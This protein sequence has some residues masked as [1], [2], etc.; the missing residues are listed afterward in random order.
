MAQVGRF[1]TRS[2]KF[3]KLIG[4]L[5]DGSRIWGGPYTPSQLLSGGAFI[6]VAL[7]TSN[8]WSFGSFLIDLPLAAA[9]TFGLVKLIGMIPTQRRT[10]IRMVVG[11]GTSITRPAEGTYRGKRVSITKPH[12]R[13]S[14][15]AIDLGSVPELEPTSA[16]EQPALDAPT[17]ASIPVTSAPARP[18]VAASTGLERLMIQARHTQGENA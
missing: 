2:R 5:P 18:A 15:V 17:A 14:R 1:Y 11:A 6:V 10:A 4:K 16:P 12:G 3:P 13:I 8:V 7:A 9:A